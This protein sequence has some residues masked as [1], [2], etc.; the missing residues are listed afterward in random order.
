[1]ATAE[2]ST[3]EQKP[4][5]AEDIATLADCVCS[6]L[7]AYIEGIRALSKTTW[8]GIHAEKLVDLAARHANEWAGHFSEQAELIRKQAAAEAGEA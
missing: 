2:L 3:H 7:L 1:M 4:D 5:C 8:G 6:E